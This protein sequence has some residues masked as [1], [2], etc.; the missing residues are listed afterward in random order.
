MGQPED[1]LVLTGEAMD[2]THYSQ[3]AAGNSIHLK[4][5]L[6]CRQMILYGIFGAFEKGSEL[7]FQHGDVLRLIS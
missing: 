5:F 2:E 4:P 1:L 7:Y 3:R 6:I